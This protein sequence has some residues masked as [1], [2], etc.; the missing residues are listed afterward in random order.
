MNSGAF[1]DTQVDG[2]SWRV[3]KNAPRV[4]GPSTRSENSGSGNRA[5]Q[6]ITEGSKWPEVKSCDVD[7]N[8]A[9]WTVT[10]L[11]AMI[12]LLCQQVSDVMVLS[13]ALAMLPHFLAQQPASLPAVNTTDI[14][15][16]INQ[17]RPSSSSSSLT[18]SSLLSYYYQ[19]QQHWWKNIITTTDNMINLFSSQHW[20]C[21]YYYYY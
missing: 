16:D 19:H 9:V 14:I 15:T 20:Y 17:W 2:P 3:S 11:V 12:E 8:T 4:H 5:L 10:E 13:A 7:W 6:R 1:F 21:Y 18:P